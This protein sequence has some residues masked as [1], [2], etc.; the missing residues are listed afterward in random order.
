MKTL[1]VI[2]FEYPSAG[3]DRRFEMVWRI[4]ER[5]VNQYLIQDRGAEK[6]VFTDF[7]HKNTALDWVVSK[8]IEDNYGFYTVNESIMA[9]FLLMYK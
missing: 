1:N 5:V 8:F 7:G 2:F 6:V 9:K 3:N 4:D